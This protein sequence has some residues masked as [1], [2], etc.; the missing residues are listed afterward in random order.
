M[1]PATSAATRAS[2][3]RPRRG[4]GHVPPSAPTGLTATAASQSQIDLALDGVDGQRRARGLPGR[5]LPGSD[6]YELR[7]G[8]NP[9]RGELQRRW[10]LGGDDV[11]LPRAGRRRGRQPERLLRDRRTRRRLRTRRRRRIRAGSRRR[12]SRTARS[13][14]P[15]RRRPTTL[16]VAGYRVE[17]CQG[18]G[19]TVFVQVAT[20]AGP[21]FNDTGLQAATS[22]SYRVRA[23]DAAGNLSGYSSVA[24]RDHAGG[25]NLLA[26]LGCLAH[27]HG[28]RR[29]LD[30][31]RRH[32]FE[33]DR[34]PHGRQHVTRSGTYS[35]RIA[36]S[37]TSSTVRA[38]APSQRRVSSSPDSL[39]AW[40]ASQRDLELGLYRFR[41]RPHLQVQRCITA[42]PAGARRLDRHIGCPGQ[43]RDLVPD[44]SSLRLAARIPISATGASTV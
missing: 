25:R 11:P 33:L 17:R 5:A 2:R 20:P 31:G 10:P 35:L 21:A 3:P 16:R 36:D 7:P 13:T 6:V 14:S 15:G 34:Y 43:R 30:G 23:A 8:G 32:L 9:D 27:G 29:C 22:Y 19:C 44:R 24:E 26:L 28:A 38:F 40:L 42:V 18:A 41:N 4:A 37:S 1:R 12:L 39:Y